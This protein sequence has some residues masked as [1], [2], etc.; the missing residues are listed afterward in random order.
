[1]LTRIEID[2]FKTFEGMA[3]DLSPFAV[4]LGPNASGKSNL[5]DAIRFLSQLASDDLRTASRGLRG[6]PHELFRRGP[7]G[8]PGT[9]MQLAAE[10]LLEPRVRDP[11]G[12]EV[13]L[14]HSR[15]RYEVVI[16]RIQNKR[17][18][19][20]L[21][22][23][24]EEARPITR[25][26]DS[27]PLAKS[28]SS[29]F[30][31]AFLKYGSRTRSPLLET[32]LKD[33]KPTFLIHRDPSRERARPA[34]AAESTILS[35]MASAE[36]PH[37]FAL[38]DELRSWRFLQLDPSSLRKPSPV[39]APE[40]LTPDGANLA[41]VLARIQAETAS[42]QQPRGVLAEIA[43]A[44][45][46]LIPGVTGL[47]VHEDRRTRE[48]HV[49]IALRDGPAFNSRV[50]SDGTLRVLALL[51]VLYDP[52]SRGLICF[53][54]PENGVHPARLST[55]IQKLQA[56]ITDP[57]EQ[58]Q[59]EGPFSQILMNSHSPV[60]LSALSKRWRHSSEV[61]FAD[62]VSVADPVARKVTRKTRLRPIAQELFSDEGRT[63]PW[64]VQRYLATAN[65]QA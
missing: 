52:K 62:I 43:A 65:T 51:T 36:F 42:E 17:G 5:F 16:E 18:I 28:A 15:L 64:E 46:A 47:S 54:E 40:A 60:V 56:L 49:D 2:G 23:V 11:W 29:A 13:E 58:E 48:Y 3:L 55:L 32:V 57:T 21:V 34:E 33:G 26:Q 37:L 1:M 50:V 10:V 24:R 22:V 6:E 14:V 25:A 20:R 53:E 4:I 9:R 44:L 27:W 30:R 61:I 12:D 31:A 19:E 35:S 41:A 45:A 7:D 39:I 38:A 63:V 59:P 8:E